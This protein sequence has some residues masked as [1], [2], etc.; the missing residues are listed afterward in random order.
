MTFSEFLAFLHE[1]GLDVVLLGL[2]DGLVCALAER[3]PEKYGKPLSSRL[4]A[5]LPF[6]LGVLLYA[7][8]FFL[9]GRDFSSFG[10]ALGQIAKCGLG[11]GVTA[12]ALRALRFLPSA[13]SGDKSEP[14]ASPEN[15]VPEPSDGK[16][17][18]DAPSEGGRSP[19]EAS[20][21]EKSDKSEET[22]A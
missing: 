1:C 16:R 22:D 19:D 10:G 11:A 4:R 2:L 14:D 6:L 17:E 12:T 7:V 18:T 13:K 5:A 20:A 9:S 21:A 8:W 3:L 15:S